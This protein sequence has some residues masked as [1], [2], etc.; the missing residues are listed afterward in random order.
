MDLKDRPLRSYVPYIHAKKAL[1]KLH[2]VLPVSKGQIARSIRRY[3]C[4]FLKGN[5][6]FKL[7]E[8]AWLKQK[9]A[10]I[11]IKPFRLISYPKFFLLRQTIMYCESN[12]FCIIEIVNVRVANNDYS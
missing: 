6:V 12:E 10:D 3:D 9:M 11:I 5:I 8:Y 4:I 2:H 1:T 7:H